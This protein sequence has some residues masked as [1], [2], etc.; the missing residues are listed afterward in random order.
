MEISVKIHYKL[1]AELG[2]FVV[3]VSNTGS[4]NSVCLVIEG[5]PGTQ[6]VPQAFQ[7]AT[8]FKPDVRNYM[9]HS[10][11]SGRYRAQNPCNY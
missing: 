7:Q 3:S 4:N 11:F 1:N 6:T 5:E 10:E 9:R 2:E 8:V